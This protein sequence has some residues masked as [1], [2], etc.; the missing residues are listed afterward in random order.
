MSFDVNVLSSKPVIKAAASMQNDGGGG[1]LG[2]M[3]Q[4]GEQ[5]EKKQN[6]SESIFDKKQEI[7]SF[8]YEKEF[9][10]PQEHRNL[11]LQVI[12][13]FIESIKDLFYKK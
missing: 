8:G 5:E 6:S 2:Y 13:D 11:I 12:I 9:S 7:D 10:L 1:N 4:G 3:M